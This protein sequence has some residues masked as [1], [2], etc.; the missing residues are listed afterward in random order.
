MS[1]ISNNKSEDRLRHLQGEGD[2]NYSALGVGS[3]GGAAAKSAGGDND[4][5]ISV[6]LHME[7]LDQNVVESNH[8]VSSAIT[9]VQ[10]QSEIL[11]RFSKTFNE[12][13]VL[14]SNLAES[15]EPGQTPSEQY[16]QIVTGLPKVDD[17]RFNNEP[18]FNADPLRVSIY[19]HKPEPRVSAVDLD[20][21][22]LTSITKVTRPEGIPI[23]LV[24]MDLE[25]I[26]D[27]WLD[28]ALAKVGDL[29][30]SSNEQVIHLEEIRKTLNTGTEENV[31]GMDPP[32][33]GEMVKDAG[34][35]LLSSLDTGNAYKVQAHLSFGAVTA[36]LR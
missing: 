34:K 8:K 29:I 6:S 5:P 28:E 32:I 9:F 24:N 10:S 22:D 3:A 13:A 15:T 35:L 4:D 33:A 27:P 17:V 30:Y 21:P 11:N 23:P 25:T 12:I 2:R 14:K 20:R 16:R 31:R 19:H 7:A 1:S 26:P 36:M 18:L